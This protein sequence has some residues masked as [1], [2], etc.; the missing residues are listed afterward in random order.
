MKHS[1]LWPSKGISRNRR[2]DNR[3]RDRVFEPAIQLTATYIAYFTRITQEDA[4]I[5]PLALQAAQVPTFFVPHLDT[6]GMLQVDAFEKC[7]L[8]ISNLHFGRI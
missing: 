5:I 7:E 4:C 8:R 1:T 6:I 3:I 2:I